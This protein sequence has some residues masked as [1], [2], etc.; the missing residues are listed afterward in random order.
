MTALEVYIQGIAVAGRS[1]EEARIIIENV[2]GHMRLQYNK[3]LTELSSALDGWASKTSGSK[4]IIEVK[5]HDFFREAFRE[6]IV[7]IPDNIQKSGESMIH[8]VL[9]ETPQGKCNKMMGIQN[10]KGPGMLWLKPFETWRLCEAEFQHLDSAFPSRVGRSLRAIH[11]LKSGENILCQEAL[12]RIIPPLIQKADTQGE[13]WDEVKRISSEILAQ[14][15][16][17]RTEDL[18]SDEAEIRMKHGPGIKRALM[19]SWSEFTQPERE[20]NKR[21]KADSLYYAL[22]K[23]KMGPEE[24]RDILYKQVM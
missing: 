20:V 3:E 11:E 14:T 8:F 19:Q 6:K 16:V 5:F 23:R 2:T 18:K 10:I 12:K 21:L 22:I 1:E 17:I 13:K 7:I 15:E 9:N 24:I 4:K